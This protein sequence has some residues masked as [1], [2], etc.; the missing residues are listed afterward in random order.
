MYG[1]RNVLEVIIE[2]Q[3]VQHAR[4]LKSGKNFT[5]CEKIQHRMFLT[6]EAELLEIQPTE[7]DKVPK[8]HSSN[9]SEVD[10]VTDLELKLNSII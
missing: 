7:V 3:L 2:K 9:F 1:E 4:L 8:E 6:K 5:L 10:D